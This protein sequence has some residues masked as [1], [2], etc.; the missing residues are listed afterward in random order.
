MSQEQGLSSKS[1]RAFHWYYSGAI[2]R[3]ALGFATNVLLARILGPTPFGQMAFV[4]IVLSIGNLFATFGIPSALIQK[5]TLTD[6]DI[7]LGHTLQFLVGVSMTLLVW[8][9]APAIAHLFA[10]PDLSVPIQWSSPIFLI[11]SFGATSMALLQRS[12]DARSI[13][14]G[15]IASYLLAY[16]GIGLPM[17]WFGFGVW[18]LIAAQQAQAAINALYLYSRVRHSLAPVAPSTSSGL[19]HFGLKVLAANLCNWGILNLDNALVGRFAGAMQLGLYSRAFSLAQTPAE[20]VSSSLQQVLLPSLSQLNYEPKRV[21]RIYASLFGLI[22]F[23]VAPPFAAMATVPGVVIGGLFGLKWMGAAIYFRPL[24]LA[25]PIHAAMAISGPLLSARGRPQ[26]ES[27]SQFI[28]LLLAIGAYTWAISH[29]VLVLSWTVLALYA[30]RCLLL[31]GVVLHVTQGKWRDL[32]AVS[33]PACLLALVSSASAALIHLLMFSFQPSLQL[34]AICIGTA[35]V[36]LLT[37][38]IG[39]RWIL[40]PIT[41]RTPQLLTAIPRPLRALAFGLR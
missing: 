30:V 5:P 34:A 24:A 3:I 6:S 36:L 15:S 10:H 21:A 28:T 19:L 41:D 31:A 23:V 40:R 9:L 12:H 14:I 39:A 7:R 13:Q 33:W 22:L 32:A 8:L 20:T 27:I 25:I 16:V 18:S 35:A 1:S 38:M 2:A 17:A 11:Q 26:L 29:S 37:W 4:L